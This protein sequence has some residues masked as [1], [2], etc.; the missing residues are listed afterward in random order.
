MRTTPT[1]PIHKLSVSPCFPSGLEH[2]CLPGVGVQP[3]ICN[4]HAHSLKRNLSLSLVGARAGESGEAEKSPVTC[5]PKNFRFSD[6]DLLFFRSTDPAS[7]TDPPHPHREFGTFRLPG[8]PP[9]PKSAAYT[10]PDP[11]LAKARHKEF[12]RQEP[13]T[14]SVPS[15]SF[16]ESEPLEPCLHQAAMTATDPH[17]VTVSPWGPSGAAQVP[18][19]SDPKVPH[20]VTSGSNPYSHYITA[21]DQAVSSKDT[22]PP[23][24]L[25]S[26]TELDSGPRGPNTASTFSPFQ[27]GHKIGDDN[28]YLQGF[29]YDLH[30]HVASTGSYNFARARRPV[31][32][33]LNIQAWR[34]YLDGYHDT[35]LVSF[36]EYGWPINFDRSQT[37]L[38]SRKNHPSAAQ[39]GEHIQHYIDTEASHNALLGPF[40]APPFSDFHSS[41]LMTAPK[42]DSEFRRVI[43]DLSWP[44]AFS[45]NDGISRDIYVDG[46]LRIKLP[47]VDYMEARLLTLGRGAFMYKTDLARGYRQLRV[48]PL[49]WGFLGFSH[50][51]KFYADICP[52]FGLRSSAMMMQRT[53][54]AITYIHA[55]QGFVSEPYIDDFGGAEPDEPT[56]TKAL[57][58]LQA[59]MADLGIQEAKHKI[60]KPSTLMV[61]LGLL[62]NSVAFTISIPESKLREILAL[63]RHWRSCT[64]ASRTEIQSL[65]GSLQF[66]AAV[67]PPA[68]AFTNRILEALREAPQRGS[69]TLSAGFK[70]DLRF[71]DQVLQDF[72]GVKIIDKASFP[73]QDSL[74]LDACLT[75]CGGCSDSEFYGSKFPAFVLEA[76]HPIAHLE[77]LNLVVAVRLWATA[78]S[79]WYV[80]VFC[81][82]SNTC[83]AVNTGHSRDPF[84][85]RCIREIYMVLAARDIQLH[86]EHRAGRLMVRADALSREHLGL[87]YTNI[88]HNDSHLCAGRHIPV[89]DELFRV[90]EDL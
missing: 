76:R 35:N 71:F 29:L 11:G 25:P 52:P 9:G 37:L 27:P 3:P 72:K 28:T 45:I 69:T 46:P 82:N 5:T 49:D 7:I 62:F 81:D 47:T 1:Q 68:R 65:F 50:D 58:S 10:G 43:M 8:S 18:S 60:C 36:L 57:L 23:M 73:F 13:I 21:A 78:W 31:P 55:L 56:A 39:F 87:K 89:G 20:N 19:E 26:V 86:I 15:E 63:V 88:I 53:S 61:W 85:Q 38:S 2:P 44:E 77:L 41:P 34:K 42:K 32:S 40:S 66:V 24:M 17:I 67:S 90:T 30:A 16:Q 74:E 64:R 4:R 75:G 54:K 14:G 22:I 79:G 6:R 80:R 48:D 84:M 33:G 12:R 59:I 51:G 83:S 70:A